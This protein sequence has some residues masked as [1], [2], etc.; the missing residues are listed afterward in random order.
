MYVVSLSKTGPRLVHA[1]VAAVVLWLIVCPDSV[2]MGNCFGLY[3]V[4][5]SLFGC[6]GLVVTSGSL[7]CCYELF[8]VDRSCCC[9]FVVVLWLLWFGCCI[10][11]GGRYELLY[12]G[13]CGPVAMVW[14]LW[15]GCYGWVAVSWSL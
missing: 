4:S 14:S 10:A 2:A 13:C 5:C 11:L 1:L 7:F 15:V 9:G 3:A 6:S 12:L 8:A